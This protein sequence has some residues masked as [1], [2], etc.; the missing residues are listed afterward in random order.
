MAPSAP[1]QRRVEGDH[2]AELLCEGPS[3]PP[4]TVM[5]RRS[6]FESLGGFDGSVNAS[7]DYYMYL[8]VARRF[9]V[10]RHEEVVAEYRIHGASMN[11]DFAL[12][13]K[14]T[15]AV[16][17]S[18]RNHVKG[19]GRY[20]EAIKR[21]IRASQD[22]YGG[23]LARKVLAHGRRGEWR[24]AVGDLLALLRYHPRVFARAC[25]KLASCMRSRNRP[26][27]S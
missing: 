17:R 24:Q 6:V 14:S 23:R 2:Y 21:G 11:H 12:M 20:E 9:P 27:D 26:S 5:Y 25:Q 8:R 3:W 1:Q 18:Q 16:L 22:Y 19:N 15:L 7:A 4:A 13:L 10:H